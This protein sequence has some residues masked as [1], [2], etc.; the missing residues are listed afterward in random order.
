M[1]RVRLF[2]RA[3]FRLALIY[4]T[5]V[6]L[7]LLTGAV[8]A[9]NFLAYRLSSRLDILVQERYTTI[10]EGY[11]HRDR[12]GFIERVRQHAAVASRDAVIYALRTAD[13]V[14][15]AGNVTA[16][17]PE[18]GLSTHH[19]Q[20]VGGTTDRQYRLLRGRIDDMNLLVGIS[21]A[22]NDNIR[23]VVYSSG[24]LAIV[25]ICL[26]LLLGGAWLAYRSQRRLDR[27]GES[28]QAVAD[29][30]LDSRLPLSGRS[31]DVDAL[32]LQINRMLDELQ[33]LIVA[34][35]QISSDVAHDLK[36]PISRLF[37][38]LEE[39]VEL[40]SPE[41]PVYEK[42]LDAQDELQ[43]I[44]ATF[45][46]LLR[47]SRIEHRARRDHFATL[48][49]SALLASIVEHWEPVAE[50]QQQHLGF[51]NRT[52]GPVVLSADADLLTQLV[53]NLVSNALRYCSG[54]A[55]ITVRLERKATMARV[56]VIDDGPGIPAEER[57][58]VFQRL[59]RLDRSRA[60]QG[61]GLGLSLVRAIARLHGATVTLSDNDPGLIV[62]LELGPLETES[63]QA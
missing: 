11:S 36:T 23:D 62:T 51:D 37:I 60:S 16:A 2:K 15:L 34:V 46:A 27:L 45:D 59:Y 61:F 40:T 14:L 17:M 4:A 8:V 33:S 7:A 1:K 24:G 55:Q 31:D 49:L 32:A 44:T 56:Q 58:R 57:D 26:L 28:L 29:G 6:L 42:L 19:G 47:L 3:P 48:D 12:D 38:S 25:S 41:L 22:D 50:E 52:S 20:D 39:A 43:G 30:H 63:A 13:G 35:D 21:H 53:V 54:G 5:L 10:S 18:A 9:A